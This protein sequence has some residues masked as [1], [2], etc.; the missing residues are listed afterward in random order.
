MRAFRAGVRRRPDGGPDEAGAEALERAV[1]AT[2]LGHAMLLL[3]GGT[4][5]R[6]ATG[7]AAE[8]DAR[9]ALAIIAGRAGL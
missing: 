8:Q 4:A 1:E 6:D 2:A 9:A 5:D 3:D 7:Q